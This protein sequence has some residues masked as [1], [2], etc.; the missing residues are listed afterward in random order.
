MAEKKEL[1]KG[2]ES[3]KADYEYWAEREPGREKEWKE[4]FDWTVERAQQYADKLGVTREEVLAAWEQDRDYWYVNYYQDCNQPDLTGRNVVTLEQWE[5]EGERLYGKNR[6]EWRFKCPTCGHVQ[7]PQEFKA[8]G[9]DPHEAYQ[10][11]ASRH[12]LGG[13]ETCKWT[14]GGLLRRGGRYVIDK[15]YCPRLI[16]EFANEEK[17]ED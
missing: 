12:G 8:A 11:C 6:L 2:Y 3:L 14:V 1:K 16:F 7:T 17:K 9:I 15:R 5:A 4:K 10:N 13:K